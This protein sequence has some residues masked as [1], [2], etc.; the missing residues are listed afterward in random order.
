MA[1]TWKEGGARETKR[2]S[3]FD[4]VEVQRRAEA[5]GS[6]GCQTGWENLA[7]EGIW[8]VCL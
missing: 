7:D 2:L 3:G 5:N 4:A 1:K 6:K 8:Q